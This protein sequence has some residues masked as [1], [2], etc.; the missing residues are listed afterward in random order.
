MRIRIGIATLATAP[1]LWSFALTMPTGVVT[2]PAANMHSA[3]SVDADVVSQAIYGTNIEILEQRNNWARVRTPDE[4][5]GW[6]YKASLWVTEKPYAAAGNIG[7]VTS[8]FASIYREADVK[9]HQPIV[10]VP[11]ETR[12]EVVHETNSG[13]TPWLEVRLPDGHLAWIQHGD[14][15]TKPGK[16][17]I[18]ETIT[19]AKEFL[20]FPYLWGGT[21][22]FG[23]DCSGFIQ[24]LYRQLGVTLPRDADQQVAANVLAAVEKNKLRPGDLVYFGPSAQKIT[25]T[26]MYIG[27][28]EFINASAHE[29]PIIQITKLSDPRWAKVFVAARRPK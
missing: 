29:R 10:T 1:F 3:P 21:S 27:N 28:G 9:K 26:G 18:P 23:Y 13:D 22:S 16:L 11:F 2:Q 6:M 14:V 4:Y 12:L 17:S 20:G 19:L 7:Q 15:T 5:T 25:H 24:M 8:L